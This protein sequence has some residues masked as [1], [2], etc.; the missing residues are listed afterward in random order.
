MIRHLLRAAYHRSI[1][2]RYV[3]YRLATAR[4][5]LHLDFYGEGI[6]LF[7]QLSA[8]LN[9][10]RHAEARGFLPFVRLSSL[11]YLDSDM[12]DD[13][14][15]YYFDHRMLGDA[16]SSS[17]SRVLKIGNVKEM[18]DFDH[19]LS[20][21]EANALFFRYVRIKPEI[22]DAVDR[23][24]QAYLVGEFTVGVHYRGTD[25]VV[26]AALLAYDAVF[27]IIDTVLTQRPG[28]KGLFVASDEQAFIGRVASRFPDLQITAFDD[29]V[30]SRDGRPVHLGQ[31]AP[32]NYLMGR[33]ALMNSL[34]LSRCGAVVRSTSFLSAWSSIFN[35]ALPVILVNTPYDHKLW[36]P[37]REIMK[38]A[39]L[40]S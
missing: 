8:C 39:I 29:S 11:N 19:D 35:P 21:A 28:V 34:I 14:F 23:F 30:R 15:Q 26:E 25:K 22:I 12:G 10:F 5:A 4:S 32:G 17:A 33:D 38:T 13:W 36:Y 16:H 1:K 18:P 20:L 40:A 31:R 27:S 6:G 37:E 9:F 7:A 24:C 3:R 2:P